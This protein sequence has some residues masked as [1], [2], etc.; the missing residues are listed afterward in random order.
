MATIDIKTRVSNAQALSGTTRVAA[1]DWLKTQGNQWGKGDRLAFNV[2]LGA[3]AGGTTPTLTFT[4]ET[5]T[6]GDFSSARTILGTVGPIAAADLKAGAMFKIPIVGNLLDFVTLTYT[7]G[8]T[9]PTNT[10]TAWLGAD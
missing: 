5:H 6:A 4:V 3:D 7:Q 10:V 8:G 2:L 1:T 9:T